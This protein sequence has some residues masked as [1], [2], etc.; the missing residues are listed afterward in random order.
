MVMRPINIMVS[1]SASFM[2]A[3]I[4][5]DFENSLIKYYTLIVVVCYTGAANA[6]KDY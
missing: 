1:G 6:F 2:S 3:Y 4:L 5:D